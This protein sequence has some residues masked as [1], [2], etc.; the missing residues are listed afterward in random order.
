MLETL[1]TKGHA[2]LRPTKDSPLRRVLVVANQ[3]ATSPALIAEL[4]RCAARGPVHLH[5]VVPALNSR[6]SHWVSAT[7]GAVSAARRAAKDARAVLM[8]HGLAVSVEVGDSVP[9]HAIDDALAQFDADE[10]VISTLPRSRSHWL[11]HDVV[12]LARDHFSVPVRHVVG[13]EEGRLV[14]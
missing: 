13:S 9:L 10:I 14:A 4:Q 7:D 5:L 6:L 2:G 1:P 8:A 3:T 12:E 11:E